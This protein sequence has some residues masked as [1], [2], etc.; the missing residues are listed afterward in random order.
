MQELP[1]PS[2]T[3]DA[4]LLAR[5]LPGG[6]LPALDLARKLL[7][8]F[9]SLRSILHADPQLIVAEKGIGS[10]GA[11]ALC[12]IPEL[13]RR[14]FAESLPV[15]QTI[16]CPS[17]TQ[18]FMHAKIQHLGHEVFCC[19]YLDNRHRVLRFD[20]LFR[21]TIDGTSVY[22]REVVKEALAINAAAVILAHNHQLDANCLFL[23]DT[24]SDSAC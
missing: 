6:R 8:R 7:L 18:A 12:A 14:Y 17:D 2:S 19:L 4:E 15:G 21:G 1:D 3:G 10:A 23:L 11:A 24:G 16:R 5:L 22:P 9:G 20:E 13:A